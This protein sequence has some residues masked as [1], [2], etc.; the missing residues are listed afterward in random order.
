MEWGGG[1]GKGSG[2]GRRRYQTL[3]QLPELSVDLDKQSVCVVATKVDEVQPK[4]AG[5]PVTRGGAQSPSA[6]VWG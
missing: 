4:A 3:E 5:D 1:M 2:Q 6:G